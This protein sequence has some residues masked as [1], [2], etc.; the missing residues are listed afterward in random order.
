[1]GFMESTFYGYARKFIVGTRQ[2]LSV[3]VELN[4]KNQELNLYIPK[5]RGTTPLIEEKKSLKE[6]NHSNIQLLDV[7]IFTPIMEIKAKSI[8][9][10]FIK[11]L[12]TF[13]PS[14]VGNSF[15]LRTFNLIAG[16]SERKIPWGYYKISLVPKYSVLEF[17]VN[18]SFYHREFIFSNTYI[19]IPPL[20]FPQLMEKYKIDIRSANESG[21]VSI[22][23]LSPSTFN[24]EDYLRAFKLIL[25]Y[26]QGREADRF[27]CLDGSK[28]SIFF[29]KSLGTGTFQLIPSK[30][31][32]N[33]CW[34]DQ[35]FNCFLDYWNSIEEL[36]KDTIER[37]IT[38]LVYSKT[39]DSHIESKL[40]HLFLVFEVICNGKLEKNILK[41]KLNLPLYD[42]RYI[43]SLRNKILH[44]YSFEKAVS[45]AY[46]E[47]ENES[48]RAN[49]IFIKLKGNILNNPI[50]GS[51][52]IYLALIKILDTYVLNLIKY[53]GKWFNPLNE[54]SE[55][56]V[57]EI[58]L[59]D[60]EVLKELSNR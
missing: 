52:K 55:E 17:E 32:E 35:F 36:E 5:K 4:L 29:E 15:L 53:E 54:F 58:L 59:E 34:L 49:S 45:Y 9:T 48:D 43:V 41:E 11:S 27:I 18:E 23:F 42:C 26:A 24:T 20:S 12:P 7:R 38:H 37:I 39:R 30:C 2:F 10:I 13:P 33:E 21:L 16:L 56:F 51:I 44:G 47:S 40:S 31:T 14:H 57:N 50:D 28:L 6:I 25:S 8:D 1:M 22:S 60:E 19:H 46:T 3:F